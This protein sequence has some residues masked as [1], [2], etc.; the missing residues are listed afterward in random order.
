MSTMKKVI[1]SVLVAA[2]AATAT[3]LTPNMALA[4]GWGHNGNEIVSGNQIQLGN[5]NHGIQTQNG[6]EA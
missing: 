3:M 1:V 5:G 6:N 4:S 2:A